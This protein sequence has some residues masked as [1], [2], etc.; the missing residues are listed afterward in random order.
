VKVKL[1]K[2]GFSG[3]FFKNYRHNRCDKNL[4]NK[5]LS[6]STAM[7]LLILTVIVAVTSSFIG[8]IISR[9]A[10]SKN[11]IQIF[12]GIGAGIMTSISLTEILPESHDIGEIAGILFFLGFCTVFLLDYFQCAHPH[13]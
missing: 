5:N 8:G 10:L 6:Y 13:E 7:F 1:E 3:M 12:I 2:M 4:H 11:T 9:K